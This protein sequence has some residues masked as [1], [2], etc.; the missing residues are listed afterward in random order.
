MVGGLLAGVPVVTVTPTS[1]PA[2][3]RTCSPSRGLA[4]G[5]ASARPTSRPA[6]QAMGKVQKARLV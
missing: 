3:A 4:G 1:G 2:S 5:W 6:S